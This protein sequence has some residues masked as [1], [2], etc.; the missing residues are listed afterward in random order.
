MIDIEAMKNIAQDLYTLMVVQQHGESGGTALRQILDALETLYKFVPPESCSGPILVFSAVNETGM[1]MLGTPDLVIRHPDQL[2]Q[3]YRQSFAIQ[4]KADKTWLVWKSVRSDAEELAVEAV[5]Y[6]YEGR[7]ERFYAKGEMRSVRNPYPA[8]HSCFAIPTFDQ[9][10]DALEEYRNRVARYSSCPI[11]CQVWHDSNRLFLKNAQEHVM[12][13]S[14]THALKLMLRDAEVRPE[15]NV[16]DSKPVDIKV[17]WSFTN[18]RAL[19]EIKWV[20]KSISQESGKINKDYSDYRAR[21]GAKQLADYLDMNKIQAPMQVTR[22]YLVIFDARRSGTNDSMTSIDAIRGLQYRDKEL[23][24]D[25]K[26]HELRDDFE[27]PVRMFVEPIC[28]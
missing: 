19:I 12:R 4:V 22:G 28:Q 27:Q 20:G 6:K 23:V 17:T 5:V 11:L 2:A 8:F 7:T 25:P 18:R 26:Y 14:L 15:Q 21:E 1:P 13:D 9:L 10:L 3:E 24:F 16:D